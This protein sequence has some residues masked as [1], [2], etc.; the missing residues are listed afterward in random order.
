[1]YDDGGYKYH[2]LLIPIDSFSRDDLTFTN[3]TPV[4][5]FEANNK[6]FVMDSAYNAEVAA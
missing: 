6:E 1:M 5:I 2:S 4:W 3:E